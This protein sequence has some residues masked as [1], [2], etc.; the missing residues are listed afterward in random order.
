[1]AKIYHLLLQIFVPEAELLKFMLLNS[2]KK[3][4]KR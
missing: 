3:I 1:M 4:W 2:E